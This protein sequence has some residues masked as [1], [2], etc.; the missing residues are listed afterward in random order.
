MQLGLRNTAARSHWTGWGQESKPRTQ[1][2]IGQYEQLNAESV[3]GV[4]F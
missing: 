4:G 2:N 3:L 1:A